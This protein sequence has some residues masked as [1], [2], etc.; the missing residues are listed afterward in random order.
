MGKKI[1]IIDD[2]PLALSL[3]REALENVGYDISV[4][5]NGRGALARLRAVR[6]DLLILDVM[7]P[8]VDGYALARAICKDDAS[9][10]PILIVTALGP[11][12]PL[13]KKFPQVVGFL[14][15]PF[16]TDELLTEVGKVL[17][18]PS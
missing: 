7:L 2:E 10:V 16:G 3:Y 14:T 17:P 1:L 12:K 13:F 4:C 18:P 6:P 9:K 15:K 5:D 11:T 8:G